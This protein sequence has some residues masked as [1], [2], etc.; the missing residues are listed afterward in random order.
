MKT[1]TLFILTLIPQFTIQN[2]LDSKYKCNPTLWSE[3][4]LEYKTSNGWV[5]FGKPQRD[6][7]SANI[8]MQKLT[9]EHLLALTCKKST[10]LSRQVFRT[11]DPSAFFLGFYHGMSRQMYELTIEAYSNDPNSNVK[12]YLIL[13][14]EKQFYIYY[15]NIALSNGNT[16]MASIEPQ[17]QNDNLNSIWL[18][19]ES[20]VERKNYENVFKIYLDKYGEP[21]A[22]DSCASSIYKD[23][24]AEQAIWVYNNKYIQLA[25][26]CSLTENDIQECYLSILYTDTKYIKTPSGPDL[27]FK[28]FSCELPEES[29]QK[30]KGIPTTRQ[31]EKTKGDL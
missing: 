14:K 12:K 21:I 23:I 28:A 22:K 11:T 4:N 20:F 3:L 25:Y 8:F 19:V 26:K 13:M 5:Y 30:A 29:Y 9:N 15:Y 27:F 18:T 7:D 10:Q 1:F 17:F 31:K 6:I 16:L 2:L 24:N